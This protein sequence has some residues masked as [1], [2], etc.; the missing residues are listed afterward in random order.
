MKTGA[1]I[2]AAGHKSATSTFK[3]LMPIGGTTVIRRII[4]TLKRSGVDPVVV[5]TGKDAKELEKHISKLRVICLRN[6]NYENTQMFDS[7]CT[8][9]NYIEDLCD[10]VLILP[11]KFPMLLPETIKKVMNSSRLAACPVFDGRRGHPIMIRKELIPALLSYDGRQGLWGAFRQTEI[12]VLIE[13]I[14]VDDKG[15]IESIETDVDDA[16]NYDTGRASMHPTAS[17]F[18]ECD[19]IFFG[20]GIAQFLMLIEHNGSMQTACRQMNMSYSK[21]WKIIKEAEKQLGYPLLITRSGGAEGGFS[22]LT[23]KTKDFLNRFLSM[24]KELNEKTEELFIKYF[25]GEL[26]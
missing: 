14:P 7:I 1:V 25:E 10:R 20:P 23:P 24:E 2:F 9:L 26:K 22:Q 16:K 6:E 11:V 17:L 13:E 18:L 5:I 8:G 15:I 4:M 3:P 21:G 12:D 19:E